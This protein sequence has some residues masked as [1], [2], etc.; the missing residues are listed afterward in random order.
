MRLLPRAYQDEHSFPVSRYFGRNKQ[1]SEQVKIDQGF[2]TLNQQKIKS[3]SAA[4]AV[5]T[6]GYLSNHAA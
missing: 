3:T 6:T 4:K 2:Q 5:L 1:E